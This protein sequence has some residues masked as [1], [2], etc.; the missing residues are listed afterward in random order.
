MLQPNDLLFDDLQLHG[1]LM[2][3][4]EDHGLHRL[5]SQRAGGWMNLH[6][7]KGDGLAGGLDA[8]DSLVAS[9]PSIFNFL[10]PKIKPSITCHHGHPHRASSSFSTATNASRKFLQSSAV[11][12]HPEEN[13]STRRISAHSSP[14]AASPRESPSPP[15]LQA[16]PVLHWNPR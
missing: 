5:I 9:H 7:L 6:H 16:L 1:Q 14:V 4:L 3:R 10:G 13:R 11:V 12:V 8:L 2:S 15:L